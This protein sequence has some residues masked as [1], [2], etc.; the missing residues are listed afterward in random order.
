MS[1]DDKGSA[2]III[3]KIII[4]CRVDIDFRKMS[5][6]AALDIPFLIEGI[7]L[8]GK[9]RLSLIRDEQVLRLYKYTGLLFIDILH[10]LKHHRLS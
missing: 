2:L 6:Q 10:T 9:V 4:Q 5:L 7:D 8:D 1:G 3:L